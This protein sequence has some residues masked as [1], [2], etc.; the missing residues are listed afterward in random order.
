MPLY[1]YKSPN[2]IGVEGRINEPACSSVNWTEEQQ[3]FT[4]PTVSFFFPKETLRLRQKGKWWSPHDRLSY[5]M[6]LFDCSAEDYDPHFLLFYST[7]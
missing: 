2:D 5:T 4:F 1:H 6:E 3:F 7:N